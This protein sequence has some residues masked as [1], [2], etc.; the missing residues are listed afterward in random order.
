M[1]VGEGH[2]TVLAQISFFW[3]IFLCYLLFSIVFYL[4][5]LTISHIYSNA[6][7]MSVHTFQFD[8]YKTCI[9]LKS[10]SCAKLN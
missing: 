3:H 9:A 5:T 2:K 4:Q 8:F 7:T 1:K 6:I 10:A